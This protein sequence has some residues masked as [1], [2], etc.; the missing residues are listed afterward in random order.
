MSLRCDARF[1][2]VLACP[3]VNGFTIAVLDSHQDLGPADGQDS[4]L[5]VVQESRHRGDSLPD[6]RV[7]VYQPPREGGAKCVGRPEVS[8]LSA[9]AA[10]LVLC[11]RRR[12]PKLSS[13]RRLCCTCEGHASADVEGHGVCMA[14]PD[15]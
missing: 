6:W 10:C 1:S 12:L 8:G 13:R 15:S 14:A 9:D 4:G 3:D 2:A 11:I 5:D 7:Y